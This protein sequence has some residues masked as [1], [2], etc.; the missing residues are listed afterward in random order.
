MV[1]EETLR[2]WAS[3]PA[4]HF[5]NDSDQL[6]EQI[7]TDQARADAMVTDG[8]GQ[9]IVKRYKRQEA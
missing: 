3:L 5:M 4:N 1:S 2:Y 6:A 7:R 8:D 9:E